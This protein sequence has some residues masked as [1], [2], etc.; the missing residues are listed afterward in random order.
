MT[1]GMKFKEKNLDTLEER[2][3]CQVTVIGCGRMGL[4]TA[5]LFSDAGFKVTCLDINP[6]VVNR[7]NKGMTPFVEPGLSAL[8][9]ENLRKGRIRA[10]TEAKEA[11]PESDFV[12]F[13]VDTPIDK[14]KRSDY[15]NLEESCREVGLNLRPGTLVIVQSTVGPSVTQ[16][17]VKEG[18]ETS[19]G[20]KAGVDFGLAYSPIR[21]S[22]GRVLR[23]IPTYAKIVAAIDRQSLTAAEAILKTIVKGELVEV[24]DIKTAEATK[25]FEN[26]YRDVNLALAN[27]FAGFCEKAGIDYIA[28]QKAAN[29]QPYCHLLRPG[30]ISGHIPKDPYLL[31]SEAENLNVKLKMT[32][33]ARRTNDE[34]VKHAYNLVKDAIHSCE[35]PV[36]RSGVAVLGVSYRPNV[37]ETKGTLITELVRLL[38]R[39]GAKV[40][41]FDPYYSYKEL[42]EQGFPAGRTLAR[43]VEG[44]DC[45]LIAVGHNKFRR[46]GLGRIQVLMKKPAAVVD[47]AHVIS[48]Q[49][50]EKE[51]FIYRG[52][53]RGVWSK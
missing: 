15:T 27:E 9:K 26:I 32:N 37:K 34:T 53:G 29:T 16:T 10:T 38:R 2:E 14:K 39:R 1:E 52:L 43:T 8:L 21:A 42:K 50:A 46:I 49:R 51:G 23:D 3:K 20:L 24:D 6:Y 30:I 45:L 44:A 11:I 17:L 41:V 36:K 31:I 25:L 48:P 22:V 28:A 19:S 35:K 13:M 7:I 4:P 33:M 18:L 40:T 47:L 12:V 5:C